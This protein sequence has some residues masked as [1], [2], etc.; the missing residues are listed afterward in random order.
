[1]VDIELTQN[2]LNRV[3]TPIRIGDNYVIAIDDALLCRVEKYP[4]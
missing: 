3:H 2:Y 1:M 4:K